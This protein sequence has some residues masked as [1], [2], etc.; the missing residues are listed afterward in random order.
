MREGNTAEMTKW[1]Q[2]TAET[3]TILLELIQDAEDKPQQMQPHT[4]STE[5]YEQRQTGT[6]SATSIANCNRIEQEGC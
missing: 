3:T 5:N 4:R 6:G 1:L 2:L